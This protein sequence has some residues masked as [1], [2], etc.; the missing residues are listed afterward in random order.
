MDREK[1]RRTKIRKEEQGRGVK[2]KM[3]RGGKNDVDEERR[4]GRRGG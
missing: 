4:T 2:A 3:R 1:C